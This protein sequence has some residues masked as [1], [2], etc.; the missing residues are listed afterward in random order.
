MLTALLFLFELFSQGK[1][2]IETGRVGIQNSAAQCGECHALQYEEWRASRHSKAWTNDFFQ[3]DY[4]SKQQQWCRNCHIPMKAQQKGDELALELRKEGVNCITCH[5]RG[6]TFFARTKRKGSP[7][8]TKEVAGFDSDKFCEGCHQFNFP[9]LGKQGELLEYTHEPMQ[10]T[11]SQFREGP[12]A[13]THTCRDCHANTPGGHSYAGAHDPGMLEQAL[14]F[15]A[16]RK[17]KLVRT[18]LTNRGAGHNVPTGDVHRHIVVRAWRSNDPAKL[19]EAFYGRRFEPLDSGGKKTIWD[20]TI[21]PQSSRR[22]QFDPAELG[23]KS[24]EAINLEVRY[25]YGSRET[26][27]PSFQ[28]DTYQVVYRLRKPFLLLPTCRD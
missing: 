23:A 14:G 15:G 11:I 16:C 28:E 17:G 8:N 12:M 2:P 24:V 10:S 7:H 4:R 1:A 19:K 5:V 22:W 6:D 13:K 9:I 3:T 25:L 21:A 20:S 18:T 27:A 26:Y